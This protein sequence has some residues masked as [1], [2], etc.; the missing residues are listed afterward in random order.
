MVAALL[1]LLAPSALLAQGRE[2]REGR[3][4]RGMPVMNAARVLI[5]N[6]ADLTLSDEQVAQLQVIA[7]SLEQKNA[8][9][10]QAMQAMRQSGGRGSVSEAD[11]EK[12]RTDMEQARANSE[13]ARQEIDGVLSAEQ[14][15]KAQ[16]LRLRAG[17]R[18]GGARR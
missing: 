15:T 4:M 2:G 12:M 14:R 8:P 18:G 11:R 10:V 17:R 16:E 3:G 9:F 5:E 13:A 1:L 7:D 6:R